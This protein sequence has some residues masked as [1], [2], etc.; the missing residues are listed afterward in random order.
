MNNANFN[1]VLDASSIIW[2]K[3]N[4]ENNKH[5]YYKLVGSIPFFLEELESFLAKGNSKILLRAEFLNEMFNGF[6]FDVLPN[7]FYDFGSQIYAFLSKIGSKLS[8]YSDKALDGL[9]SNPNLVHDYYTDTTKKE[10]NYLLTAM[11]TIDVPRSI[12]FTYQYLWKGDKDDLKTEREE[13]FVTYETVLADNEIKVFFG[14]FKLIFEHHSKKHFK[15]AH[16]T[17]EAWESEEWKKNGGDFISQ[18]SCYDESGNSNK[19][20]EILDKS[21]KVSDSVYIGY[22]DDNKEYVVFRLTGKNIFHAYDEYDHE[23]I[24]NEVKKHFNK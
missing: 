22:D 17:R 19:P 16:K 4:Y 7:E 6:P 13:D 18:L 11:H 21:I 8:I 20:Q 14:K 2:D 3:D 10:L 24:P 12:Y 9:I 23:R 1:I 15:A 5:E